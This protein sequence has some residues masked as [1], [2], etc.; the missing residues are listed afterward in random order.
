M[1]S[2]SAIV[3]DF[4]QRPAARK[5]KTGEFRQ[6]PSQ[7]RSSLLVEPLVDRPMSTEILD[8]FVIVDMDTYTRLAVYRAPF[9]WGREPLPV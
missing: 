4:T 1:R 6:F 8:Q 3:L 9:P 7:D 2:D 5:G